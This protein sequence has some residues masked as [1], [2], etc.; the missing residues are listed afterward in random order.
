MIMKKIFDCN[1]IEIKKGSKVIWSDPETNH[2]E[3]F[4]PKKSESSFKFGELTRMFLSTGT[5][6]A[7]MII[8]II[9]SLVL[10]AAL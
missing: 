7:S 4:E 3:I 10:V 2:K 5:I 6:I 9:L 1:G 8:L